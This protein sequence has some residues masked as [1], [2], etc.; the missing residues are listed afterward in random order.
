MSPAAGGNVAE[1]SEISIRFSERVEE[2]SSRISVETPS[3]EKVAVPVSVGGDLYTLTMP[4]SATDAGIYV[5][6]WSVVS[7]D[8]GHFTKGSFAFAV[9]DALAPVSAADAQ[10][11]QI[12]TWPEAGAM[13]VEFFGNSMLWGI[14]LMFALVLRP[15]I[16]VAPEHR[17]VVERLYPWF[18]YLGALAV[19]AGGATQVLWKSG[20][21]AS[22][23]SISLASALPMYLGTVAGSATL[24]RIGAVL[25]CVLIFSIF[26]RRIFSAARFSLYEG[27]LAAC[28]LAFAYFRAIVSH[29]TA[30]PFFP[31]LSTAVNVLHLVEKDL[32]L[33]VLLVVV[34]LMLTRGRS[35]L[36]SAMSRTFALLGAN[37]IVITLS[38]SYIVWLHLKDFHNLSATTWGENFLLLLGAALVAVAL[39]VYHVL[40]RVYRPQFFARFFSYTIS[41]EVAAAAFVVLFSSLVI[42]TSPPLHG[43]ATSVFEAEDQGIEVVLERSA[44]EDGTAM[45]TT[46]G[47]G[48]PVVFIGEGE[49]A[50]QLTLEKRFANGYVFP[51]DVI[52]ESEV[53]RII[54]P[55]ESG[56]DAHVQ[57]DVGP[58]DFAVPEG[59]GRT[60]DFFT[61]AMIALAL[62]GALFAGALSHVG[63]ERMA[64]LLS[65]R[66]PPFFSA[67]IGLV[68]GS[69]AVLT[70]SSVALTYF[71]N[72]FR[73]QCEA[74]GDYWHLMQP[75]KGGVYVSGTPQ[76]GCMML[77]ALYHIP[78]RREYEY[79]SA[80]P[81]AEVALSPAPAPAQPTAGVPTTLRLDI[82]EA[83][84]S[85]PK[86]SI[87]HDK[88]LHMVIVSADMSSFA[89]VH[90]ED[91]LTEGESIAEGRFT[92]E[93][94]F[95]EAGE[96][97]VSVD[98]V[99]G[100][101]PESR[102]FK[103]VVGGAPAMADA[104]ELFSVPAISHSGYDIKFEHSGIFAGDTATLSYRIHKDGEPVTDMNPYLSA[105]MH[106]AIVKND[107]SEFIHTHGETHPPGY[108]APPPTAATHNHAPPPPRF[109]PFMEA[110][111]QLPTPGLYTV[112]AEFSHEGEIV[113]VRTTIRIE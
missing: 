96:Y 42:I 93:H 65:Y 9:G 59:H 77:G 31:E 20:E 4:L 37:L 92:I 94:T 80:L 101:A 45:L 15:L 79:M 34:A 112:F 84:G 95:P 57:F 97:L 55:Q 108:V 82:S 81:P 17:R 104:P 60:L 70:L 68:A 41:A 76:E 26:R 46:S 44:F 90:P 72:D 109:G 24:Y 36:T 39:R 52:R 21:L 49:G 98:Y 16:L 100:F 28:L 78:D 85:A 58:G 75:A 107:L 23:H 63:R 14:L 50:L 48:K 32:W 10:V 87:A 47:G 113:V 22:L 106:L 7:R 35:L 25:A 86:L 3:G 13:F 53:V 18:V 74:G 30:N 19:T 12:A 54:V 71:G 27:A 43:G 110:H 8:D 5:A 51:Y 111:A 91:V 40:A 29:A 2:G 64:A 1:V 62:V 103:V 69:L 38:A 66:R 56:Y 61:W 67:I 99:H 102:Q 83:D 88:I 89:H 6:S 33:G 105:A 73:R 11:V